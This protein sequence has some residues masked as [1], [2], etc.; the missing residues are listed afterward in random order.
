MGVNVALRRVTQ[1]KGSW[2]PLAHR[3]DLAVLTR[4]HHVPSSVMTP[5]HVIQRGVCV[6]AEN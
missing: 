4:E 5:A 1:S 3:P 2:I 6:P